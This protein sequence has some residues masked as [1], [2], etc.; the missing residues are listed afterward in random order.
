MLYWKSTCELSSKQSANT[1]FSFDITINDKWGGNF[2]IAAGMNISLTTADMG[3]DGVYS[4]LPGYCV[5]PIF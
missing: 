5:L 4:G 2:N 1:D 3:I